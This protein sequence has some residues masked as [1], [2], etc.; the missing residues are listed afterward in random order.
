MS[1][2]NGDYANKLNDRVKRCAIDLV[3]EDLVIQKKH[4]NGVL[5]RKAVD[6]AITALAGQK[7]KMNRNTLC[8]KV[9]RASKFE[10]IEDGPPSNKRQSFRRTKKSQKKTLRPTKRQQ[11]RR[12]ETSLLVLGYQIMDLRLPPPP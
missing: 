6:K 12:S 4:I 5:C 9:A 7:V 8:R 1:S 2:I 3:V 10:P 11:L